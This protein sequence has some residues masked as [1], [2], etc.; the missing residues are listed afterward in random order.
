MGLTQKLGLLAQS[1]QQDT[2]LNIGIGGAANASFKLQVTGTT[3]L[4]G[5]LSVGAANDGNGTLYVSALASTN[6][7]RLR[8]DNASFSTLDINN[9][10]ASGTG[11]YSVASKNYFSGNVG[12][13]VVTDTWRADIGNVRAIQ[14]DA[15]SIWGFR[16]SGTG[17]FNIGQNYYYGAA[18]TRYR[19]QTGAVSSYR[20]NDG[21]HTWQIAASGSAGTSFSF[22]DAMTITN[23]GNV[24]IGTSSPVTYGARNLDVNAGSGVSAYIVARSSNNTETIELAIDGGSGYLSTKSAHPL[25]LRTQDVTRI[26][27]T[28]DGYISLNNIVYNNTVNTSPRTLYIESGTGSLGG[29]SSIRASKKNI[30]DIENVDWIYKLNPVTFNYRK[31]DED[32]NYTNE[33]HDELFYGLIAEDTEPIADFLVNYNDKEDGTKEMAGIEYMRLIT[34]MLKA[35]Q[36]LKLE[37]DELKN[38]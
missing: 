12:I 34:P 38:K 7:A 4:T 30:Q 6:A 22:T 37:I 32:G 14:F 16:T 1:V 28:S 10:N 35:I 17:D 23:G 27:I 29:I 11:V 36:E 31:K 18:G 3:N 26:L 5:A 2:S 21:S 9:A 8:N 15:G 20:Q 13:G 19:L 33:L 24:G 25:R